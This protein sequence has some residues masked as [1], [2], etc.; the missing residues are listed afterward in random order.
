MLRY[1][2]EYISD[3]EGNISV[4]APTTVSPRSSLVQ[5]IVA[6]FGIG[7][8]VGGLA[9]TDIVKT[10]PATVSVH[11]AFMLGFMLVAAT[12]MSLIFRMRFIDAIPA[13]ILLLLMRFVGPSAMLAAFLVLAAAIVIGHG[14]SRGLGKLSHAMS[15]VGGI[16]ILTGVTGWLLPFHIHTFLVYLVVLA[17][18]AI[19][20]R[21]VLLHALRGMLHQ[22]RHATH[23]AP[24]SAVF[25][26]LMVALCALALLPPSV[27]FDD[28]AY[29]MLLP[30]Q[31]AALGHYKMD[32]ASQ[33]W[34]AAP[35]AS[36]LVQGFI[37]VLSGQ[38]AR[39]AP[40][41]LWL[42]LSLFMLWNLGAE[43]GLKANLR[44]ISIALYATEPIVS[45]L[46]GSMQA[47]T[48][49]TTATLALV[50][51]AARIIKTRNSGTLTPF[52]V[53]CGLLMALKTSQ[54]LLIIPMTLIG[55]GHIGFRKFFTKALPRLP[56]ALGICGSSYVYA[57][58][59]TGN[60]IFP[61]FNG[62]FRSPYAATTNFDDPRWHRGIAWDSLW[63]LTFHTGNYQEAYAG[64]F[65][66]TLL[67]LAG[68]L[69]LGLR[70]PKLRW[71][72]AGL[73]FSLV[74]SFA[75]IQY[76]RYLAP[77]VAP[78]TTMALVAWQGVELRMFG[79]LLLAGIAT[80][81]AIF[82]PT[83]GYPLNDDINWTTFKQFDSTPAE[84][85]T[86]IDRR[87]AVEVLI[88]RHMALVWPHGYS[89]YLASPARPFAAPFLGQA[90]ARSWYDPGMLE[91]ATKADKD[92]TGNSW[93]HLFERTGM[94]HILTFGP[95]Q[96]GLAA[97]LQQADAKIELTIDQARL[98]RLCKASCDN[99]HP[100]LEQRD[101]SKRIFR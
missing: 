61:L 66:F 73:L 100:L 72:M 37:A 54:A 81:N 27:Q 29:H 13:V 85:R 6:L 89:L 62:L 99:S 21:R 94:T 20:G 32:I 90:I 7:L 101:L 18:I 70:L 60:P 93:L 5:R 58:Y 43:V 34:A 67:A 45:A 30:G 83:G 87:Y 31:L 86:T 92:L 56:L 4:T 42:L 64:A 49:I 26:M 65:G 36:D 97:S 38:V 40:N 98:W 35:W 11:D 75:A 24:V 46:N 17:G 12:C 52:M 76:M 47:D 23:E 15:A 9:C 96:G 33:A 95:V 77:L 2:R 78:L 3:I 88:A 80:L 14:L 48:A 51:L 68:C 91:A 57:W 82:I 59:F 55:L 39:G 16:A 25:A 22:W 28:L 79:E 50:T 44:W 69:I 1:R 8:V 74:S 71:L 63:Q 10:L 84:A 41:T 19:V 53:I